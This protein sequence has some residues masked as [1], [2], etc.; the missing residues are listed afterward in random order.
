MIPTKKLLITGFDCFGGNAINPSWEA[1]QNLP[2]Q[3]SE[4]VLCKLQ[5][6]TVFG[7]AA[8][9]VLAQAEEFQPDVILCVGLASGRDAVTPERI[10]VNI[11]DARISDNEG[12]QPAGAPVCPDGPAA[13]FS[14]VP[15]A[16]MAEAIRKTDLPA[17]VSNTAGTFVCNDTLYTL[18]HHYAGTSVRVGFIHV[19]Q[20]PQQGTPSLPLESTVAALTAAIQAL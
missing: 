13:Y 14:T 12:N 1:V 18:L 11:R 3:I 8:Q 20:L 6:P 9:A 19:P 7:K 10:A 4:Y 5:I 16:A 2:N 17:A 15:V